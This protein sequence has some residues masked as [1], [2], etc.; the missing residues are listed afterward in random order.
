[1]WTIVNRGT[2]K[3]AVALFI[4]IMAVPSS[5]NGDEFLTNA[6]VSALMQNEE[7]WCEDLDAQSTCNLVSRPTL[8]SPTEVK[9]ASYI[10]TNGS[11]IV[12]EV[13]F[14]FEPSGLC[15]KP[16]EDNVK[17][18]HLYSSEDPTPLIGS[19]DRLA[20]G[21]ASEKFNSAISDGIKPYI[22]HKDCY[23]YKIG[24]GES[25]N[26]KVVV[27]YEFLDDIQL[28]VAPKNR[29]YIFSKDVDRLKLRQYVADAE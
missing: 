14:H 25:N 10:F 26:N 4:S 28:T 20:A 27:E 7:I 5:A 24:K 12:G 13:I 16:V 8:I 1:M 19:S 2:T 6:E 9:I 3:L 21:E 23:K 22:G 17:S 11:K 15:I 18:F 29:L